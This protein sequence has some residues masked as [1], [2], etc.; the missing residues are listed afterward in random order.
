VYCLLAIDTSLA[1]ID[2][3]SEMSTKSWPVQTSLFPG[4]PNY[5]LKGPESSL[6]RDGSA[7]GNEW[8]GKEKEG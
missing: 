1:S 7:I 3:G 5:P 2:Y 6:M 8:K 4:H